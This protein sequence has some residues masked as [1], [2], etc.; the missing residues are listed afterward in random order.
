MPGY[1]DHVAGR[2][3]VIDLAEVRRE[4]TNHFQVEVVDQ[5]GE[6]RGIPYHRVKRVLKDDVVIRERA[7]QET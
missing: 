3:V 6:R 7:H 1:E 4:P 2:L 5:D